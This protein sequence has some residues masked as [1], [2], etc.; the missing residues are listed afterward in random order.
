MNVT[1]AHLLLDNV[2]LLACDS[3]SWLF[4]PHLKIVSILVPCAS[5]LSRLAPLY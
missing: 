2:S 3:F 1:A 4:D 5:F